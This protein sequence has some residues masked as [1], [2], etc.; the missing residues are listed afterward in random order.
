MARS[1]TTL[2][3]HAVCLSIGH[4]EEVPGYHGVK[5]PLSST[6]VSPTKRRAR[7]HVN[8]CGSTPQWLPTVSCAGLAASSPPFQRV[9]LSSDRQAGRGSG[10]D[11][12]ASQRPIGGAPEPGMWS[13]RRLAE[14]SPVAGRLKSPPP[15]LLSV[16]PLAVRVPLAPAR[17][18][19]PRGWKQG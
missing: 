4:P 6:G 8:S 9:L 10:R 17:V 19:L 18:P 14:L 16:F 12:L 11:P 13:A 3:T 7:P 5:A 15:G 1:P 2:E